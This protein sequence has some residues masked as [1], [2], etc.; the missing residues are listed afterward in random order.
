MVR[1]YK[2]RRIIMGLEAAIND[3]MAQKVPQKLSNNGNGLVGG[4]K[5]DADETS[6]S[7]MKHSELLKQLGDPRKDLIERNLAA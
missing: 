7:Q 3:I 1:T 5:M 4:V 2:G 6:N